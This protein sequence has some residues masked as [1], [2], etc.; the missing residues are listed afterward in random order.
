[1]Q[2]GSA[3]DKKLRKNKR[4]TFLGHPVF[5]V[6]PQETVIFLVITVSRDSI[7]RL[8]QNLTDQQVKMHNVIYLSAELGV[9]V[10][11][12]TSG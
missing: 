6:L 4:V 8:Y 12:T 9:T 1:V 5:Q 10:Q 2:I 3:V 11:N 7:L